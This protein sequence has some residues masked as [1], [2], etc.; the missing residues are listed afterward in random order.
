MVSTGEIGTSAREYAN[1]IMA[2]SN[3]AI[4]MIDHSDIIKIVEN[5]PSIIQ[6]LNR[7]AK[8]AMILKKL[9]I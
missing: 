7:E 4:I 2:D 6:T 5:P 3:I 8:H 1:K 9:E